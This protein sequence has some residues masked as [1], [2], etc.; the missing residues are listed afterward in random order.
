[1]ARILIV[2]DQLAARV[3]LRSVLVRAGH[4]T[5][6]AENGEEALGYLRTDPAIDIVV[7][8]LD[9]PKMNGVELLSQLAAL[10]RRIATVVVTVYTEHE[11]SLWADSLRDVDVVEKPLDGPIFLQTVDRVLGV[12][13][14]RV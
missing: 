7:T 14:S 1:M 3:L 11:R 4:Q 10:S 5:V 6:L 8:D 13:P 9:M 2:E 12:Q